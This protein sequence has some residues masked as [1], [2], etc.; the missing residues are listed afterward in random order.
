MAAIHY[1]VYRLPAIAAIHYVVYRLPAIAAIHY[2]VY[3]LPAITAILFYWIM[4]KVVQQLTC[5]SGVAYL[6]GKL[7]NTPLMIRLP[8]WSSCISD[9]ISLILTCD[10]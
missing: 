4:M 7:L 10:W 5:P 3:R 1:V 2:V 9:R 8:N 6:T